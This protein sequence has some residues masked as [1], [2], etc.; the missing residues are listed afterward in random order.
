MTVAARPDLSRL[1]ELALHDWPLPAGQGARGT[2]LLV[3]GL[4]EHAGRYAHVAERLNAWGF[5]VRGHDH[6]GHG[7]SAGRRG[8]L[9]SDDQ[10]LTDLAAVIDATRARMAAGQPLILLGHSLG[11]LVAARLVSLGLR[12]VD[13]LVL[14]SPALD[15]GLS[16]AQKLL[17]RALHPIA[18]GLR[19]GNGLDDRYLSHDRAMVAAYRSD[20]LVHDRIGL[21][22]ARFIASAGPATLACAPRWQVPTLLLFAGDDRLVDPAGSRAFARAAPPSL[23]TAREFPQHFHELFNEVERAPVFE[24]LHDW[25]AA[26]HPPVA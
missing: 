1:G 5:A 22:L 16:A 19:L 24:A 6:F 8:A 4:G 20:P 23:V 15:A 14:S 25:L 21:R 13:S 12:R 18:P 3:H 10:L 11:G 7:R 9:R 26:R 2:L 17:L